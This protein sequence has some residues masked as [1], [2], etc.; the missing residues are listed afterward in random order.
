[1]T[2]LRGG[3]REA[4]GLLGRRLEPYLFGA[5]FKP[6]NRDDCV[7][8]NEELG[9]GR[10]PVDLLHTNGNRTELLNRVGPDPE[11]HANLLDDGSLYR[12]PT[13]LGR[14]RRADYEP[15]V[16]VVKPD[17]NFLGFL[18]HAPR[19]KSRAKRPTPRTR[20]APNYPKKW[21]ARRD[22]NPRPLD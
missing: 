21:R 7:P 18:V 9:R 1:M 5:A 6:L 2:S 11:P 22:L 19:A 10:L 14:W 4:R 8:P 12:P 3:R 20:P 17:G 16:V 15:C 13:R